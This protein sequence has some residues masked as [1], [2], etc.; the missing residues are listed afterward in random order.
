LASLLALT[1]AVNYRMPTPRTW[2]D[3]W[4]EKVRETAA[5][6]RANPTLPFVVTYTASGVWFVVVPCSRVR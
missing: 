6:C 5:T 1:A 2:A 3:A 4:D